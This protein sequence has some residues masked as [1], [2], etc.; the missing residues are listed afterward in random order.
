MTSGDM[1][2]CSQANIVPVR[3][4]P[5]AIS[6]ATNSKPCRRTGAAAAPRMRRVKAHAACS[7]HDRLEDHGGQLVRVP[8]RSSRDVPGPPRIERSLEAVGRALGEYVLCQHTREQA[9]A[10][11]QPGRTPPSPRTCRRD[12]HRAR[13]TAAAL[14][15]PA[16]RWYCSAIL[17]ATST[18]TEPES[19]KNTCSMPAGA[20]STSR[21]ASRIAGSCVRPPNI[22]CAIRSS[23]SRTAASSAG[24]DSRGSRTTTRTSRRSARARRPAADARPAP[25]R[26][27]AAP[28]QPAAPRRGARR[29]RDRSRAAPASRSEDQSSYRVKSRLR[30]P[31]TGQNHVSG[32]SSNAVPAGIPPSGSPSSGS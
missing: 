5:V 15:Q 23:C 19:A 7:L 26:Q 11:R 32:M 27:G 2:A 1:P 18:D 28:E 20:I 24:G 31:H 6:S 21:S 3:P 8:G 14:G 16:A 25:R 30:A 12:S 4:K 9:C 10:S 17:I 22:T 29:T 13:S